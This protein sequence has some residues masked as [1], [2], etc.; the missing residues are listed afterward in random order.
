MKPTPTTINEIVDDLA[1]QG[2][3]MQIENGEHTLVPLT[4]DRF[5]QLLKLTIS[6]ERCAGL[7]AL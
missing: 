5:K 1:K 3:D 7:E 4:Y 2:L 6:K